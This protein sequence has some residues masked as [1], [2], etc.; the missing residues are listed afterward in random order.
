MAEDTG[1]PASGD[2][3]GQTSGTEDTGNKEESGKDTGEKESK[4]T[5]KASENKEVDTDTSWRDLVKDKKLRAQ[6]D[7]FDNPQSILE[8]VNSLQS[9]ISQRVKMPGKDTSDEDLSKYRKALKVPEESKGYEFDPPTDEG[10]SENSLAVLEQLS[11][12]FHAHHIPAE[13]AKGVVE[14]YQEIAAKLAEVSQSELLKLQD[15][16]TRELEIDWG[17]DNKPNRELINQLVESTGEEFK[18]LMNTKI[19]GGGLIGDSPTMM[20]FLARYARATSE[21]EMLLGTSGS[22]R[23]GIQDEIDAMEREHPPGTPGHRDKAFQRKL[24][25]LYDIKYGK[26][27]VVGAEQRTI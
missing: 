19:D 22:E 1:A 8:S 13:A 11:E 25:A 21:H 5:K 16:A 27:P 9:E 10:W 6:A 17:T 12:V 15:E 14:A 2:E 26:G 24:T 20:L 3:D 7:R 4:S 18:D 23:T